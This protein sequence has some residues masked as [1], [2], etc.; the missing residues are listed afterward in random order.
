MARK[1]GQWEEE[2]GQ[3]VATGGEAAS[4]PGG[5]QDVEVTEK[6][7]PRIE[8]KKACQVK[9]REDRLLVSRFDE[10]TQHGEEVPDDSSCTKDRT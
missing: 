3:S 8:V 5:R 6:G 7:R 1:A 2:G 9:L 10:V 4:P